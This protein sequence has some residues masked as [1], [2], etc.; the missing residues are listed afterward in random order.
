MS[1]QAIL[2]LAYR[3]RA[4]RTV[5]AR[6]HRG[7]LVV[8]KA[9]YPEGAAVCHSIVVHPPGGIAGGDRL[10]LEVDCGRGAHALLTTPG[11]TRWYKADG[12]RAAQEVGLRVAGAVEYLPQETIVFDAADASSTISID[13]ESGAACIGWDIVALGRAASGERFTT[14]TFAQSIRLH[15]QG[16]LLWHERTRIVGGDAL[17][18]SPVGLAGHTVFGCFWAYGREW[19]DDALDSLRA[20]VPAAAATRLAPRLLVARALGHGTAP[21]RDALAALWHAVR[22]I[23]FDGRTAVPPRIWAT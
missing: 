2:E 9:L 11:A 14:G 21:V 12:R 17:L 10:A 23:L 7:P 15:E 16:R 1:W 3:E 20:A 22:P 18:A 4:G 8:Q 6:R 19:G 13:A 5:C